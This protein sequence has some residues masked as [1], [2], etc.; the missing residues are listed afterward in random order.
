LKRLAVSCIPA[1]G[2]RAR[3]EADRG[4]AAEAAV[5]PINRLRLLR[6]SLEAGAPVPAE[7]AQ[8]AA[9]ALR[10]YEKQAAAGLDL[11]RAF[12]LVPEPGQE[13]WWTI[14]ERY[15]RDQQIQEYRQRFFA[16]FGITKAAR[17]I[18]ADG[19]RK[20][21]VPNERKPFL[22]EMVKPGQRFPDKRR[23]ASILRN[24]L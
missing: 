11:G 23:I 21:P 9:E 8:W 7:I 14:E 17:E 6:R 2:Y 15:W 1:S 5:T 4:G 22:A 10:R 3:R 16:D 19:H 20:R 12:G 13:A 24:E 18:A